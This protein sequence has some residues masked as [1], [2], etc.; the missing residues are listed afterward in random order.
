MLTNTPDGDAAA[1]PIGSPVI[2]D[3]KNELLFFRTATHLE[4]YVEA[5]DVANGE[6]G[7]CWDADGRLLRLSIESRRSAL[8]G[9]VPYQRDVVRV[10]AAEDQPAH[11][12]D[13]HLALL[14]HLA[15][16]GL[17]GE[18][19]VTNDTTDLLGYA[20]GLAGWS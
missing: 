11:L 17:E 4:T 13:L 20:I 1:A 14:R 18:T 7:A 6:Y 8:L 12:T 2:L 9:V 10:H 19:P 15:D 16:V 5:I 3:A